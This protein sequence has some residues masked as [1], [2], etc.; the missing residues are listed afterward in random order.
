MIYLRYWNDLSIDHSSYVFQKNSCLSIYL[1]LSMCFYL[2]SP[3]TIILCCQQDHVFWIM[4]F[5][6]SIECVLQYSTCRKDV[7][8][9][10]GAGSIA[11]KSAPENTFYTIENTFCTRG[12]ILYLRTHLAQRTPSRQ[13]LNVLQIAQMEKHILHYTVCHEHVCVT[14]MFVCK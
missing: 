12:H 10:G 4:F 1:F 5:V 14:N 13:T 8:G 7:E 3:S 11:I 9:V 2:F 6:S